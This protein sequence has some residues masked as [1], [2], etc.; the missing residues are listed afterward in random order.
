[1]KGSQ[2]QH[3]Q[4][5][6]FVPVQI[7]TNQ[8]FLERWHQWVHLQ[9]GKMFRRDPDRIMDTAQQIR[10]R[11]LSKDLI[12]RWFYKHLTEDLVDRVQAERMLGRTDLIYLSALKPVHG[13]RTDKNSLWAIADLLAFAKFDLERFYYTPQG[14]TIDSDRV[15][16]LIGYP[17]GKYEPLASLYRQ[18]RLVPSEFTEHQ[19]TNRQKCVECF[20]GRESLKKR[21]VSL[22]H[23]WDSPESVAEASKLRWNDAQVVPFLRHWHKSNMIYFVPEY[24]MRRSINGK[25]PQGIDA[26]LLAYVMKFIRNTVI[27]EFKNMSRY[28]DTS[29]MVFNAGRCPEIGDAEAVA[30]ES[31]DGVSEDKQQRI[32]IDSRSISG[33][34]KSEHR[35]DLQDIIHS[36]G[37]D[38]EE[39]DVILKIDLHEV[40]VRD[41]AESIG[42][43]VQ[44]VHRIRTSAMQKMRFVACGVS[45][46]PYEYESDNSENILFS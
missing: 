23:R 15:L 13:H 7:Y 29:R 3:A 8:S 11:L 4:S 36:S 46:T 26:G 2:G 43:S 14:H 18:G 40:T 34:Q 41:Y 19:C 16:E 22:V 39:L 5:V 31:E 1:M 32:I 6:V 42:Y 33:Y 37:L 35:L 17:A 27:N 9:V 30:F 28:D 44:K 10:Q 45:E 24:I 21:K 20:R 38:A 12:G 25:P